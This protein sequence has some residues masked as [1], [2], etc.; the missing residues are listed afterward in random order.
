MIKPSG[1]LIIPHSDSISAGNLEK[2]ILILQQLAARKSLLSGEGRKGDEH[3]FHCFSDLFFHQ[4]GLFDLGKEKNTCTQSGKHQK[5]S[6]SNETE[7]FLVEAQSSCLECHRP[8][9]VRRK[10][11]CAWRR[12]ALRV[13]EP[14]G[15]ALKSFYEFLN[16][17]RRQI[18]HAAA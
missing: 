8:L 10:S 1:W 2:L 13:R 17:F 16:L 15:L 3:L 12:P 7:E 14:P 6:Q 11:H 4:A 18:V 5:S 9:P